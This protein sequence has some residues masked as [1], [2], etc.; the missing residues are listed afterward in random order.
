[1]ARFPKPAEGS[2][3]E[4]YPGLGTGPVSYADSFTPEFFELEREAIFRRTWLHVG[5]VEQLARAGSYFTKEIAVARTSVVVVRDTDGK[6]RA[7]HNIC[8][9]RGNKLVWTDFPQQETSG[10]S[11]QM[12]CKY[13]GWRYGLDGAC[14]FVQQESE[15][16]DIDRA[17]YGLV[18]VHCDI[19][20]G[21]IF[22]NLG[23]VPEQSLR[24]SL[25][26]MVTAIEDYPFE[27][28]THC[29]GFRSS[30]AASWKL[31]MDGLQEQYHAP[32]VH[33]SQRP[34]NFDAHATGFE[35]LHYQIE[36]PHRMFN[37]PGIR[38]WE[39]PEDQIK[40]SER[41]VRGG[42]FGPWDPPDFLADTQVAGMRPGGHERVG[43]ALFEIWPNFGIQL[44][45]RGWYHTYQHWPTSHDSHI[46]E[47][48]MYF[49]P[50]RDARDLIAQEMTAVSLKEFALQDDSLIESIQ[51]TLGSGGLTEFP[52][53]DQEVLCR[54]LHKTADE[55]VTEFRNRA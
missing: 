6:V 38:P 47:W 41:L 34:E 21:F 15:F 1:M 17:E 25:G 23:R 45:E 20:A 35:A 18:P 46:F 39:L 36:G 13:H 53:G 24:E 4:H 9:H 31:M 29:Y 43:V 54:H 48:N 52:L 16:F 30:V 3:T 10:V 8:R 44:W 50:P 2:W 32:I 19:W 49:A 37:S 22:I 33:R 26:P 27:R 55:W 28:L 14:T 5:R 12:V 7:F 42:L 51:L 11:R 40:P